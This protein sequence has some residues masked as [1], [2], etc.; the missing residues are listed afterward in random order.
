MV[1]SCKIN[2]ITIFHR[3]W[4]GFAK[5]ILKNVG[6]YDPILYVYYSVTDD[7]IYGGEYT[8][9]LASYTIDHAIDFTAF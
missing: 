5:L 9:V 2:M 7:K 4:L 8:Q 6:L 1:W 3:Y